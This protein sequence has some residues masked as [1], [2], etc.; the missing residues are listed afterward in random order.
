MAVEGMMGGQQE[1]TRIRK[2]SEPHLKILCAFGEIQSKRSGR[3]HQVTL[4]GC[5]GQGQWQGFGLW[6]L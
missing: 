6:T 3:T 2:E 4:G 5:L 1:G